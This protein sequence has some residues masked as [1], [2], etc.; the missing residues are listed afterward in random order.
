MGGIERLGDSP[1][2]ARQQSG[3]GIPSERADLIRHRS[4]PLW[5][6]SSPHESFSK[7]SVGDGVQVAYDFHLTRLGWWLF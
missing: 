7:F 6:N 5:L 3:E 1:H 4:Q 2:F